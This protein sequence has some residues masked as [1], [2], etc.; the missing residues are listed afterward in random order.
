MRGLL[1]HSLP[2]QMK[3]LLSLLLIVGGVIAFTKGFTES[4]TFNSV[5]SKWVSGAPSDKAIWLMV[6]G[7]L[8]VFVGLFGLLGGKK[9]R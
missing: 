1:D 5:L 4:R 3:K 9:R 7:G 8:G 2:E 6:G